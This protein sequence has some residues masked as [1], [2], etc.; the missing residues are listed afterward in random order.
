MTRRTLDF[1]PFICTLLAIL[2]VGCGDDDTEPEPPSPVGSW[3]IWSID[4]QALPVHGIESWSLDIRSNGTY[5]W[6]VRDE[7]GDDTESGDWT[8]TGTAVSL[9]PR[10]GCQ[11]TAVIGD[12]DTLKIASDCVSGWELVFRR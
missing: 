5:A 9:N 3:D 4:G 12:R 6:R 11:N 2:A 7:S 1:T 10:S 8:Q